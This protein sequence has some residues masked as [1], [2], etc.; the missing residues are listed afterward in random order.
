MNLGVRI[1][2][3]KMGVELKKCR[4]KVFSAFVHLKKILF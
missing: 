4:L 3:F 1:K 2:L